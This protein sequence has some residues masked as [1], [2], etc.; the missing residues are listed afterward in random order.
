MDNKY[1]ALMERAHA[2]DRDAAR[3]L[4]VRGYYPGDPD[5]PANVAGV[6]FYA[7]RLQEMRTN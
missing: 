2:G 6:I 5:N 4:I 7:R 3:Q 1:L